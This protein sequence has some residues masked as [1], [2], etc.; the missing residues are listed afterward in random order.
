MCI[1]QESGYCSIRHDAISS[2]SF[3]LSTGADAVAPVGKQGSADCYMDFIVI[4]QGSQSGNAPTFDRYC[5]KYLEHSATTTS[6]QSIISKNDTLFNGQ[7]LNNL[8]LGKSL[9]FEVYVHTNA[10]ETPSAT[11]NGVSMKYQQLP[12]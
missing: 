11:P 3:E 4:P 2:T 6:P 7:H 12:C 8:F 5:G 10:I 1:R 9:P